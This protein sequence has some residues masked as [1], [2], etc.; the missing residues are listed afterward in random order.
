MFLFNCSENEQ[1]SGLLLKTLFPDQNGEKTIL[2]GATRTLYT[3]Y[4]KREL[5][6]IHLACVAGVI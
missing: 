6:G 2:F 1:A 5:H 3:A 4:T